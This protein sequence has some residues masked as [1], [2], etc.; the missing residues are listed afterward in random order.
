LPRRFKHRSHHRT[1]KERIRL[2]GHLIGL[3]KFVPQIRTEVGII[4]D[5]GTVFGY[6]LQ[7]P[8]SQE[9]IQL[10]V[11]IPLPTLMLTPVPGR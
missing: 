3:R 5:A 1:G 8:M 4:N 6:R 10:H 11:V 9:V 7:H 2:S